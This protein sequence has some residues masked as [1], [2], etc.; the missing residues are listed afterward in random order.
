MRPPAA[1]DPI[2]AALFSA[3][4]LASAITRPLAAQTVPKKNAAPP[5]ASSPAPAPAPASPLKMARAVISQFEDG[6][7]VEP[8]QTFLP[9]ETLFFS[10]LTDGYKIG[11]SGQV[12][13][14]AHFEATDPK[15][16]LIVPRDEEVIGTTLSQEDK[17][18]RPKFR[19]QIQ[20]PSIA[21][22]G[23]YKIRYDAADQQSGQKAA[24]EVTF[25]VSGRAVEASPTL[26]VRGLG[27]YRTQDD[28]AALK[29]PAFREGD[30]VW[31]RCDVTG[32]K[33]GEQNSIDVSYDVAVLAPGGKQLFSQ[34]N[35][36]VEKSQAFYPQPWI[37]VDFNITLQPNTPPGAYTMV[38]TAHDGQGNQTTES[39]AEFRVE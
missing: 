36:A 27:F 3:V 33:Y 10:F 9:G 11:G 24:G 26:V 14:T 8:S 29:I 39:R 31:V 23:T 16:T 21:P 1:F 7:P 15:G 22:T 25:R 28:E 12:R 19:A 13:L 2:V 17:E 4:L 30:M 35:A 32:Y 38:I 37:P 5:A 34:E 20:L 18:W 6:Q